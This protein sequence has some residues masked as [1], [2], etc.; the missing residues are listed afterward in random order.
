M[1]I[2]IPKG[3]SGQFAGYSFAIHLNLRV[4]VQE[5]EAEQLVASIAMEAAYS[6][7]ASRR[8]L[9]NLS[10]EQQSL[11]VFD[12]CLCIRCKLLS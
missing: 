3:S 2:Y 11:I 1:E 6:M 10:S 7:S 5:A 8:I 12:K 4:A 9:C